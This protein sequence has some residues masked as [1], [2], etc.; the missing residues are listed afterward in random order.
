MR[1]PMRDRERNFKGQIS[2]SSSQENHASSSAM[3]HKDL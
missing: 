3:P 2:I 1:N